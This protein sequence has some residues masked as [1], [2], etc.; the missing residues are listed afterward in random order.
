MLET[1][2]QKII[3]LSPPAPAQ[4]ETHPTTTR[5]YVPARSLAPRFNCAVEKV[6]RDSQGRYVVRRS[7][8]EEGVYDAVAVCS[9]LHNVPYIPHI[10]GIETFKGMGEGVCCKRVCTSEEFAPTLHVMLANSTTTN[11]T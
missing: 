10:P 4:T 2:T 1:A 6:E 3:S 9:G 5:T 7:G 11:S 8:G